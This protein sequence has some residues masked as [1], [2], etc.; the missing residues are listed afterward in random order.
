MH[1]SDQKR[2][3]NP[4][5]KLSSS[6]FGTLPFLLLSIQT[7]P[8]APLFFQIAL[9][10]AVFGDIVA[11]A[12][13]EFHTTPA[14]QAQADI[15]GDVLCFLEAFRRQ[16]VVSAPCSRLLNINGSVTLDDCCSESPTRR[17]S[18]NPQ[19]LRSVNSMS[20]TKPELGDVVSR[21]PG[22][23]QQDSEAMKK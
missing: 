13:G 1:T 20:S 3:K 19:Q 23:Y 4:D 18:R 8:L 22:T 15:C 17:T 14:S 9:I 6:A 11:M 5:T 10:R 21:E 16:K 12:A 2:N 7:T